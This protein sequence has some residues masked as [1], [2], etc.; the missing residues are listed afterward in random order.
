MKTYNLE[1]DDHVTKEVVYEATGLNQLQSNHLSLAVRVETPEGGISM[2]GRRWFEYDEQKILIDAIALSKQWLSVWQT[3]PGLSFVITSGAITSERIL[4]RKGDDW[5]SI[6]PY[7]FTGF[8]NGKTTI[9]EALFYGCGVMTVNDTGEDKEL[10][11]YPAGKMLSAREWLMRPSN[12]DSDLTQVLCSDGMTRTQVIVIDD[13][14]RE[15]ALPFIRGNEQHKELQARYYDLINFCYRQ[16]ISVIITSNYRFD[17]LARYLG[18]ASWSRLME[19]VP[20]GYM[21]DITGVRDY[22]PI[23]GGR[24]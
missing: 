3:H 17:E 22:R 15:R 6:G 1:I 24:I 7:L 16:Q 12:P 9:A 23:A 18:G 2:D 10:R 8:G 11:I 19:M 21:V 4:S 13:I 14:G 5:K 20:D